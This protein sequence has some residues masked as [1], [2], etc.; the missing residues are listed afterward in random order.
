MTPRADCRFWLWSRTV[1]V[2]SPG[3]GKRRIN[4]RLQRIGDDLDN[5]LKRNEALASENQF[6]RRALG[7][8]EAENNLFRLQD[9]FNAVIHESAFASSGLPFSND[10]E[11]TTPLRVVN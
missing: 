4:V 2:F 10:V 3:H 7:R 5:A 9:D 1:G 11:S 8:A 6:L